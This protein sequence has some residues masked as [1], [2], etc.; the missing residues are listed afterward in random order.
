MPAAAEPVSPAEFA[1]LMAPLGPFG[2]SPRIAA[3]VSGGPDSLALALLADGWAR[4]RGGA[5]LALVVDHGLRPESA[6]EAARVVA[7]LAGRGI[8]ARLLALGL[9]GGPGLQDRARAARRAALLAACAEAGVPW[10]LLGHQRSDQAETLLFRALR[11]SG[12][13]GLAAMATVRAA[14]E[15]LVLRPLLDVP[16]ARLEAVVA[17][18]GLA[19]VR[20]PSNADPRFARTRLRR[21]LADPGGTGPA[22]AAL[23]EAAGAFARRR[24]RLA[25]AV[26]A[27]LAACAVLRLAGFAE[28]DPAALGED[29][30]ADAAL[31]ALLRAVAGAAFAPP[32][33]AV[34]AL[35]RRGAGTLG[36]A[37]LL[38]GPHGW[39][40]AREPAAV[41][42]PVPAVAGAVWDGRFRLAGPG[43]AGC[44]IGALGATAAARLRGLAPHLPA[45][46][47]ATLPAVRRDGVLE[48]VPGLDYLAQD[49]RAGFDIAFAPVGDPV[50]VCNSAGSA[51][52]KQ[53]KLQL[54]HSRPGLASLSCGSWPPGIVPTAPRP[55]MGRGR[56]Q[57]MYR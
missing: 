51:M 1:A 54:G 27:R 47:L 53:L 5:L 23:A 44:W 7:L 25:E 14:P 18:A 43:E 26:C 11:G 37:W 21:S 49:R 31:A 35:R 17:A 38:P 20:D 29:W 34:A 50:S 45:A 56:E 46:I 42:P 4:T 33:G 41:A 40:L 10:L 3:G 52:M 48:A 16:P 8:A 32:A 9:A 22:T 13:A 55:G 19:P 30:V 15:A 57:D 24:D 28:L 6:A 2:P 36:G 12:A 39:R